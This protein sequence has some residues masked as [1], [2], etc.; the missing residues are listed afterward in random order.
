MQKQQPSDFFQKRHI[1]PDE[2]E[3]QAMLETCK[4]ASVEELIAQTIPEPIRLPQEL[5]IDPEV[6]EF[7]FLDKMRKL[8][9]KNKIYKSYLGMGYYDCITPPVILRNIMEN[10]GWY[11]QYTP[12][13]PEISQGRLE[14]L[15]NFQTMVTDLTGMEIA[16]AS[17]LDEGTAAAEAMTLA[18]RVKNKRNRKERRNKFFVSHECFETSIAV[19]KTRAE[20]LGIELVVGDF[21]SFAFDAQFFGGLVQYPTQEGLVCD[22]RGFIQNVHEAGAMAVFAADLL[23]LVLLKP[24]GELGADVVVGSAQRF[25]VPLGF[26]GPHAAYFATKEAHTREIPGRVIGVSID[27]HENPAYRMVLQTREQHIKRDRATSNICTAQALLAIMAGMYG[28]YHGAEG[29]RSI[30]STVHQQAKMLSA[31]LEQLGYQQANSAFFDTLKIQFSVASP[32]RLEQILAKA[33][34]YGINLRKIDGTSLGISVDETTRLEDIENL[35]SVFNPDATASFEIGAAS[36]AVLPNNLL[37]QGAFLTHPVFSRHRSETKMLRYLKTLENKDL[38]LTG[39]MIPLG[40]CTMKLN[41]TAQM[42]PVTWPEFGRIH[43]FAPLEQTAGYAE[44]IQTLEQDLCE[45]TGLSGISLQPNSGAQGEYTGL[46]VIRAYHRDRGDAHRNIALIPSSAHGTNPASAAMC[47]MDVVVVQC[48]SMGNID[49]DDLKSK[50]EKHKDNLASLMITYPSTHGVYEEQILE[51]CQIVHDHGGQIYMDGANLNAQVGLTNPGKIGADVCHLNLHKT[52]SIPHGGGG[53][54]MGPICVAKHLTPYLPKHPYAE[55]GGEK[56]IS[57]IASAPW[58]SASILLIS[59][60]YIKMLG[61]RGIKAATE[62]AILNANYIKERLSGHYPLLFEG[63]NGRV[64]HEMIFDMRR[65]QQTAHV[66]V[67]DIAKRLMD[68][69]FHAPTVSFPVAGTMMIE[70]TESEDKE[71]LDRFCQAM[72]AIREEIR[73]IEEKRA[74]SADNVLKNAPHTSAAIASDAWPHPYSRQKAAFPLKSLQFN[75]F[76]PS[77]GRINESYGDR[78]LFCA[79]PPIESWEG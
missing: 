20:P 47:G 34:S 43:P 35:L 56:A 51:I 24:P 52:F 44:I 11:T 49:V 38:S 27:A 1:G 16:N 72:I 26:G 36:A 30:A 13:Q 12:Y 40:S 9:E 5:A 6:G 17:L 65:F 37:R 2:Q 79:C 55:V 46:L 77:V 19:L 61:Q 54:G 48:D 45:I 10:P 53:P 71:E 32:L 75:K 57:P 23:S 42:I 67:A 8:A 15:L 28:V 74:D 69:G 33:L 58:G 39:C 29:L 22:Y 50:A 59:Y 25:G 60:A 73:E 68:Y 63:K 21:R 18:Y 76:W 3:I 14:A 66:E 4:V 70:P 64:A 62:C 31:G 78:N 7:E 41:A